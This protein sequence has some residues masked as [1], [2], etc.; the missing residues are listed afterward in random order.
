MQT[1][2]GPRQSDIEELRSMGID[3][4]IDDQIHQRPASSYQDLVNLYHDDL[5]GSQALTGLFFV[6]PSATNDYFLWGRNFASAFAT[7][8]I[9]GKDQ[10]RQRAA[11][12]LS[13]IFVISRQNDFVKAEIRSMA[14]FY[15]ML[16]ENAFGNYYELL[17]K[18]SRHPMMGIYLSS[19]ANLPPDPPNNRY[20]DENYGREVMQL[21]PIGIH[22]L[23]NDGTF[24]L[25]DDGLRIETYDQFDVTE[26]A[27]VMTGL[28]RNF[29]GGSRYG[30]SNLHPMRMFFRNHDFA[31]KEVIKR[32]TIPAREPSDENAEQDLDDA[33]LI[34]FNHEN[35]PP[36]VSKAL[37]QFL[38]T[39]NPSPAYVERVANVFKNDG[40]G[41]RGNLEAVWKA[42]LLDPEARDVALA[43]TQPQ[44]GRLRDPVIRVIHLARLLKLDRFD[45][46]YWWEPDERYT[47]RLGQA[48]LNA[49][50]VFN[51][52]K[53]DYQPPG[54]LIDNGLV[55]GPFE[56]VDTNTAVGTPN[57][58]WSVITEGLRVGL[59]GAGYRY[60]HPPSY[61]AL[62]PYAED[63][64]AL[65][66][67]INLVACAGRMN[68][69]TRAIL[70]EQL[71]SPYFANG[72][73]L[74][75]KVCLALYG[76]AISP[77]AAVSK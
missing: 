49:S 71:T 22:L 28:A 24:K 6:N 55:G 76:A 57:Y 34:L 30:G 63:T 52:Y 61:E 74:V 64:A 29:G 56:I 69:N 31:P 77:E 38:I 75:E 4:W 12:A 5:T 48:P 37:I 44:F 39:D 47:L 2:F 15:D 58:L 13:Q 9:K 7:H 41:V 1:T 67:H 17:R 33:L 8:T 60:D 10:L 50:S 23:N 73:N 68:A 42:I 62:L 53:P 3:A 11:F 32:H 70:L 43:D 27:R 16:S 25:N 51:F 72:K 26:M 18:V 54:P 66:D 14:N 65:L 35:T 45:H 46:I 59:W 40:S 19:I 21:F 36:F 20:P